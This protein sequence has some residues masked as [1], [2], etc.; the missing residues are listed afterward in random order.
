MIS[1]IAIY[2]KP[3]FKYRDETFAI[4]ATNAWGLLL[5]ARG[6]LLLRLP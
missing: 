5:K 3:D 6:G 4:L 2:N 1:V